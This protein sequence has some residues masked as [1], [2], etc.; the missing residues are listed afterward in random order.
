LRKILFHKI[1]NKTNQKSKITKSIIVQSDNQ[2]IKQFIQNNRTSFDSE[3]P[4]AFVWENVE[5]NLPRKRIYMYRM[6]RMAAAIL[7]ILSLGIVIG[8]FAGQSSKTELA[9]SKTNNWMN[10][11]YP[12]LKN[13][14]KN[15]RH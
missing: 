2:T 7:L 5:K 13:W 14:N 1:L 9:F 6:M 3:V 11:H 4:P 8:R 10:E 12:T 15:L